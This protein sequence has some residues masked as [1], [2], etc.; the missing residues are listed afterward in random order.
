VLA[1]LNINPDS[2]P[3]KKSGAQPKNYLSLT[4]RSGWQKG[5]TPVEEFTAGFDK[6]F[7]VPPEFQSAFSLADGKLN[8]KPAP[9]QTDVVT[10]TSRSI[11]LQRDETISFQSNLRKGLPGAVRVGVALGPVRLRM[12]STNKGI[13]VRVGKQT[14]GPLVPPDKTSVTFTVIMDPERPGSFNWIASAGNRNVSGCAMSPALVG[15]DI[16]VALFFSAPTK[17]VGDDVWIANLRKGKLVDLPDLK[18]PME[19]PIDE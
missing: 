2:A 9:G 13:Q 7:E 14:L 5:L 8:I 17:K 19:I 12:D 16:P 15:G 11:R 6:R 1:E 3:P 4:L 18:R 10:L